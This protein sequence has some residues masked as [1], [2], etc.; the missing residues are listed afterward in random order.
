MRSS[1]RWLAALAL[2]VATGCGIQPSDAIDAG[3]APSGLGSGPRLFFVKKGALHSTV[4]RAEGFHRPETR[5]RLLLAGPSELER[6]LGLT[7]DLPRGLTLETLILGSAVTV[8][9]G[10]AK[11]LSPLAVS[12]VACTAAKGPRGRGVVRV[13]LLGGREE[14]ASC[15]FDRPDQPPLN[16][17]PANGPSSGS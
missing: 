5:L 12:Q 7:T 4:R 1:L 10:G 15:P 2:L 11:Q 8:Y 3:P 13:V 17:A 16:S 9:L 6:E 14:T